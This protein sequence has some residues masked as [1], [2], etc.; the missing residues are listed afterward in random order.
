V[1]KKNVPEPLELP[2]TF[3]FSEGSE[4][5][6]IIKRALTSGCIVSIDTFEAPSEM[7]HSEELLFVTFIR[8][9]TETYL[10]YVRS[11][12]A[13]Y[14]FE[15]RGK[16]IADLG[17]QNSETRD[18]DETLDAGHRVYLIPESQKGAVAY[19]ITARYTLAHFDWDNS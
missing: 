18:I 11:E 19:D 2:R 4:T 8:D 1:T 10:G 6:D 14:H 15:S 13:P 3:S 17:R 5:L 7:G 16:H 9:D 12:S